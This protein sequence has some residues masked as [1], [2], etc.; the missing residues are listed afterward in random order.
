MSKLALVQRQ[1]LTVFP[2]AVD[3]R[4]SPKSKF[5]V[6]D[7]GFTVFAVATEALVTVAVAA[8][9]GIAYHLA[10]YDVVGDVSSY[11]EVGCLAALFYMLPFLFR[12]EYRL[13]A[14]AEGRRNSGRLFAVWNYTFL[15]IALIGFLAKV[16]GETSRGWVVLFYLI[17][18][19]ATLAVPAFVTRV[20]QQLLKS[21]RVTPRRLMLIGAE[22]ELENLALQIDGEKSGIRIVAMEPLPMREAYALR[23]GES[24]VLAAALKNAAARARAL[25]VDD[26]IVGTEWS[27]DTVIR[28]IVEC[29]ADLPL[30][31]HLAASRLLGSYANVGLSRLSGIKVISLATPPLAP[32]QL[33]SKRAFDVLLAGAALVLLSP[34]FLLVAGAIKLTSPGPVF[35]RQRRSGYNCEEFRI[36]KFRTMTTLEDG[37]RV[38]QAARNDSR[39]TFVGRYLRMLNLDELPQ[40]INVLAGEM[41]IVGPR[42]HAV[43]HDMAF[44]A[45]VSSYARRLNV[46]PGITGW[47]QVNGFRGPTQNDASLKGRIRHDLYYIDNWSIL[48]DLCIIAL[49]LLSPRS[50]RNAF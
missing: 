4:L 18:L 21:G 5:T 34:L 46:L 25:R 10:V 24:R 16:A 26:V 44:A 2:M 15:C 3:S 50:Y 47:A 33:L 41:S 17:G 45:R 11:V 12:D 8:A 22:T 49:T 48:F 7:V 36:W 28:E 20:L 43:T 19:M 6:N 9:T 42:P 30:S 31:I 39:V 14:Y 37:D 29:F 13:H 32:L 40:L 23:A 1:E 38:V 35:F 27:R